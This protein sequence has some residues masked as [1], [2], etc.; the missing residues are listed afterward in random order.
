MYCCSRCLI[1]VPV[2]QEGISYRM[3][4]CTGGQILYEDRFNWRVCPI[5]IHVSGPLPQGGGGGGE[6]KENFFLFFI[7]KQ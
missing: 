5:G 7:F 3:I 1:G 6:E 2:L 4:C